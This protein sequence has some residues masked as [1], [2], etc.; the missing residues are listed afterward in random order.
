MSKN[1]KTKQNYQ[2]DT[3]IFSNHFESTND[4]KG[5]D[6]NRKRKGTYLPAEPG[7]AAPSLPFTF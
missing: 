4:R 7:L 1:L 3:L 5:L 2:L 6:R